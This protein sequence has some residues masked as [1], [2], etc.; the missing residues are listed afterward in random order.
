[1]RVVFAHRDPIVTADSV[2][3]LLGTLF[4][5]RTDNVWGG[6]TI[7]AAVLQTADGRAR[8]WDGVIAMIE[9]GRL[10]RGDYANFYYDRFV[11]DPIDAIQSVYDQLGMTLSAEVADR[12]RDYL[13][14]K[15]KGQHGKH[16]YEKAPANAVE[17]ERVHYQTYQ[18]FFAVPDEI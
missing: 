9:D 16:E 15:T 8:A 17:S 4:W 3:S 13:A 1:M 14:A 11:A 10:A 5:Q 2:V 7:D 18:R 12:M 6:G